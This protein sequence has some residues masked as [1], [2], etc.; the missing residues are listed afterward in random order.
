MT[1]RVEAFAVQSYYENMY[2]RRLNFLDWPEYTDPE[3]YEETVARFMQYQYGM[4][5]KECSHMY[6]ETNLIHKFC[7]STIT[8]Y[9]V[10]RQLCVID[11]PD[12]PMPGIYLGLLKPDYGTDRVRYWRID[13][14][15]YKVVND[16]EFFTR[17]KRL[18]TLR[19][20]KEKVWNCL[21]M[22]RME[23]ILVQEFYEEIYS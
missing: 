22:K 14:V 9:L 4:A 2:I 15:K 20:L 12:P 19:D 17:E 21:Y 16:C 7:Q 3:T 8:Q 11:Y 13:G 6:F 23:A 1:K 5:P 10:G 18:G